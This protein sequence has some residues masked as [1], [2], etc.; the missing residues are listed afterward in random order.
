MPQ[1]LVF[2]L[3]MA[4]ALGLADWLAD[5]LVHPGAWIILTFLFVLSLVVHQIIRRVDRRPARNQTVYYLG[6]VVGRLMLSIGF[7]AG[8][9]FRETAGLYGFLANFFVL[10]LG[11]TGF[12]I[13]A[14]LANLRRNSTSS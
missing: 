1:L 11:Y 4:G 12:E 3:L 14:L 5:P 2:T 6:I 9:I 10:Y 8:F 7:L 13:Y